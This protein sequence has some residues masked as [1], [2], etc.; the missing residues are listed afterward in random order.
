MSDR[1]DFIEKDMDE[2]F[3]RKLDL[4]RQLVSNNDERHKLF[5][6]RHYS[7]MN[8]NNIDNSRFTGQQILDSWY[9]IRLK[10]HKVKK[11]LRKLLYYIFKC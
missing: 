1:W 8:E 10:L 7:W 2:T 4:D 9:P 11:K 3:A 5:M 6:K